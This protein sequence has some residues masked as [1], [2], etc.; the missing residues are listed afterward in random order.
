MSVLSKMVGEAFADS[1]ALAQRVKGFNSRASQ[2]EMA[3]AVAQAIEQ[4]TALVVEAGTGTGKTFAYL[5]PALL[6]GK[7]ILLS[8]A[9]KTLQDQLFNKDLPLVK[10][11][12]SQPVHTALLKGRQNY[13]C[14]FH[15]ERAMMDARLPSPKEA[16]YL[17]KISRFA[18]RTES[19]DKAECEGVPENASVWAWVTSNKDN[20]LGG[21]CPNAGECFVTKA[22]KEA[23]EAEVVVINHHL[24]LA[25]LALKE[26]GVAE[27]LPQ[28]D[29]LIF[30][31]AH[32][33]PDIATHLLGSSLSTGQCQE[34]L[35]DCLIEGRASARDAG[36][37]D[38]VIDPLANQLKDIRRLLGMEID[39]A[40]LTLEQFN[41]QQATVDA[42]VKWGEGM[43][44]LA[45]Q[46]EPLAPR[47]EAWLKLYGRATELCLAW[48]RWFNTAKT[49]ANQV[50][51]AD[52]GTVRWVNVSAHHAQ[53]CESPL[54]VSEAFGKL[55][56]DNSKAWV[57]TSATL[58]VKDSLVH[59]NRQMGLWE[60]ASLILPSPFDY[61]TQGLLCVP[62]DLPVPNE[63]H[64]SEK[65]CKRLW[66]LLKASDGGVFFLC[67]SLRAVDWVGEFLR[68]QIDSQQLDWQLL[69]QGEFSRA[70]LLERYRASQKPVLVGAASFWEG[71]DIRGPQLRLVVIDKL[72]F[73]PPDDPVFQARSEQLK[74]EGGNPFNQL[75]IPDAAIALKQ[76]AGRLIRDE[77]DWGVLL[78]GDRR[79]VE[80]P[81]GKLL[82]RSL[83]PFKRTRELST[84]V[85]FMQSK[86]SNSD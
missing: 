61:E 26:E 31:E 18:K 81:Y 12:L 77:S 13:V 56:H 8:T 62:D 37:W 59:F 5:V 10:S 54:D 52:K 53:F 69:V 28:S 50:G 51:D 9:T 86:L 22:R 71:V 20:C 55:Y 45:V 63:P 49:G 47:S 66:P 82:W 36:D 33:L 76:G 32:Q 48:Q 73:A 38:A 46:L 74:R 79:L 24:F 16:E 44:A 40:R 14:H 1:G 43:E 84:A 70:E 17:H 41:A 78:I 67:T 4:N 58:S 21:E 60:P 23:L 57:F 83:P 15:L 35:R 80:K 27:L 85:E 3:D 30:D 11:A 25:D 34:F 7:R 2:R 64:F 75:S 29:V 19:G 39:N 65:L 68:D 6:S 72:P 42:C